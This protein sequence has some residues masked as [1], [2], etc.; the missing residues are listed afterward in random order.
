MHCETAPVSGGA[1]GTLARTTRT[2][3]SCLAQGGSQRMPGDVADVRSLSLA[4]MAAS[5]GERRLALAVLLVSA[6][7]FAAAAPFS[8]HMLAPVPAFLPVYQS[9]LVVCDLITATL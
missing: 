7:F 4:T 1:G 8:R 5:A 2:S 6:A 3:A 9:A